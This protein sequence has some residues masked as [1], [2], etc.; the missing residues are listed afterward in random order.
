LRQDQLSWRENIVIAQPVTHRKAGPFVAV[1]Q[2]H[3]RKKYVGMTR[4]HF[5]FA[6]KNNCLLFAGLILPLVSVMPSC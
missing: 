1:Y 3:W 6:G 4:C 5:K 2:D